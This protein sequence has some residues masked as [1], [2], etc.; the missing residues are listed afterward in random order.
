MEEL[1]RWCGQCITNGLSKSIGDRCYALDADRLHLILPLFD[2][3][4]HDRV[5]RIVCQL[6]LSLI[7][8]D[9]NNLTTFIIRTNAMFVPH[10]MIPI[11]EIR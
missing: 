4:R 9:L 1:S 8:V 11:A 7:V 6:L 3:G 2:V 5:M 10:M